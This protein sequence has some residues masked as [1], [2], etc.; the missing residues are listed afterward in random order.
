MATDLSVFNRFL[1]QARLFGA[2]PS[3]AV[4]IDDSAA[5]KNYWSSIYFVPVALYAG[6]LPLRPGE[7]GVDLEHDARI[8]QKEPLP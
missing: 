8:V 7:L 5:M 6:V 4:D 3:V 2:M 1:R